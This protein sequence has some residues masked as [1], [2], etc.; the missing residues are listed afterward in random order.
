MLLTIIHHVRPL[1]VSSLPPPSLLFLRQTNSQ[2]VHIH[3][4][5]VSL[6]LP[7]PLA[8]P[9]K[10]F[11]RCLKL[12]KEAYRNTLSTRKKCRFLLFLLLVGRLSSA[13]ENGRNRPWRHASPMDYHNHKPPTVLPHPICI[14]SRKGCRTHHRSNK[15]NKQIV[16]WSRREREKGDGESTAFSFQLLFRGG[17]ERK[18]DN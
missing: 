11:D 9:V 3:I 8:C 17:R 2:M 7:S 16:C 1:Y 6:S 5:F 10:H 15:I 14:V 13:D 18:K 12:F 4:S